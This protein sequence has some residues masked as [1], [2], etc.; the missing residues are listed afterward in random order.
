MAL[1]KTHINTNKM[2]TFQFFFEVSEW[3]ASIA[4]SVV[5]L[6][7]EPMTNGCEAKGNYAA[8]PSNSPP[9]S[10]PVAR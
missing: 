7:A 10:V 6:S 4:L 3:A 5:F 2:K 1:S 9:I 8:V